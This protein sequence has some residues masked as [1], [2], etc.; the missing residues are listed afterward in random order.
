MKPRSLAILED[1]RSC[2]QCQDSLPLGPRP[3]VVAN[4]NARIVI[5]GQAPGAKVHGSG[6]PWENLSL[7]RFR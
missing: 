7:L 1:I 6:I 4:P 3:I 2:R 5:I